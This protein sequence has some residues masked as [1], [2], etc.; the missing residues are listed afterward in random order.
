MDFVCEPKHNKNNINPEAE[1]EKGNGRQV[2]A[3][4]CFPLQ[5]QTHIVH[6]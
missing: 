5:I 1:A 4:L 3:A 2:M 6:D